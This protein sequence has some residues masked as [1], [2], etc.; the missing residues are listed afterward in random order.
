[1]RLTLTSRS[2]VG[3]RTNFVKRGKLANIFANF[4]IAEKDQLFKTIFIGVSV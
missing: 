4:L 3:Q 1:M 2:T